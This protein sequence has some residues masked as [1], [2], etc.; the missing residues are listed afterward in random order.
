M[1]EL[2]NT[3]SNE[4]DIWRHLLGGGAVAR[5]SWRAG[6]YIYLKDGKFF[7]EVHT[8]ISVA[9]TN[10]FEWAVVEKAS[11]KYEL[12]K[13]QLSHAWE[14]TAGLGNY[15]IENGLTMFL[16]ILGIDE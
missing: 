10:P 6:V 14:K 1:S 3:F 15:P 13:N 11:K 8:K 9:F 7:D 5:S 12:T 2:E 16:T 4:A